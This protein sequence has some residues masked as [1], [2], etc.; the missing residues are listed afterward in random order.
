MSQYKSLRAGQ[1]EC[2]NASKKVLVELR[3]IANERH[4]LKRL[5]DEGT[6]NSLKANSRKGCCG[7]SNDFE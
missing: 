7:D 4:M 6:P 1:K 3:P 5:K 2:F